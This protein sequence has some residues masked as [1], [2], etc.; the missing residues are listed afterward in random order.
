MDDS[1]GAVPSRPLSATRRWDCLTGWSGGWRWQIHQV[2]A[3]KFRMAFS[4]LDQ[5]L[6]SVPIDGA[7]AQSFGGA[8]QTG[9]SLFYPHYFDRQNQALCQCLSRVCPWP[10]AHDQQRDED[11]VIVSGEPTTLQTF[12]QYRPAIPNSGLSVL[13]EPVWPAT[14]HCFQTTTGRLFWASIHRP[15]PHSSFLVLSVNQGSELNFIRFLWRFSL[16]IT[17]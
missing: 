3:W 2:F 15:Q 9:R 5:T 17:T 13:I 12:A 1:A 11:W 14:C 8:T 16:S 10:F 6:V 4:H 7:V